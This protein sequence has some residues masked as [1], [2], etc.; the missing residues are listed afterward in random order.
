MSANGLILLN[1][2]NTDSIFFGD[3]LVGAVYF[4]NTLVWEYKSYVPFD[5]TC[6][7]VITGT[8]SDI[9]ATFTLKVY[10][11]YG[12]SSEEDISDSIGSSNG[13]F[14][15]KDILPFYFLFAMNNLPKESF[16]YKDVFVL[17]DILQYYLTSK[18]SSDTP[19]MCKGNFYIAAK[20]TSKAGG[21]IPAS[22]TA[23]SNDVTIPYTLINDS[24]N[25][26][27][28][29]VVRPGHYGN[30]LHSLHV[31][32]TDKN[33]G[34]SQLHIIHESGVLC[35]KGVKNWTPDGTGDYIDLELNTLSD[36]Y[37]SLTLKENNRYF[38]RF[39]HNPWNAT[40]RYYY[41]TGEHFF[42][43]EG[44]YT[45]TINVPNNAYDVSALTYD[46][47]ISSQV[48]MLWNFSSVGESGG[49]P[50]SKVNHYAKYTGASDVF[51]TNTLYKCK[52]AYTFRGVTDDDALL[53][54]ANDGEIGYYNGSSGSMSLG[55]GPIKKV[56]A[57]IWV[58]RTSVMSDIYSESDSSKIFKFTGNTTANM[59]VKDRF[60]S[61]NTQM[62]NVTE[63][64]EEPSTDSVSLGDI[65]FA[66]SHI[67]AQHSS[68]WDNTGF[69]T[70]TQVNTYPY[71]TVHDVT[72]VNGNGT[73]YFTDG[74]WTEYTGYVG[75]GYYEVT[76]YV[77]ST[78]FTLTSKSAPSYVVTKQNQPI[79]DETDN[80][81]AKLT[82]YNRDTY[83]DT[84]EGSSTD[85]SSLAIETGRKYEFL[86]R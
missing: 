60:Y 40:N 28:W 45:G 61:C 10:K 26:E 54:A 64:T 41:R 81:K 30:T 7:L 84:I 56:G 85:L 2:A 78:S 50:V 36:T 55:T 15:A 5:N 4:G 12:T 31:P 62:S 22:G 71:T 77:S 53:L 43:Y 21:T 58:T 20:A 57:A 25:S 79:T 8:G 27:I 48:N 82:T 66:L 68:G 42:G 1:G 11:N 46:G 70:V 19:S 47:L 3:M 74:K 14:Y 24:S 86:M 32:V 16:P 65:F 37:G 49:T 38:I 34:Y 33:A 44:Y 9:N 23:N 13:F 83:F 73:Y 80:M 76:N 51:S 72:Y 69:H 39:V 63:I 29:I 75:D 18:G 67:N 59:F 17:N 52:L 6:T 35:F